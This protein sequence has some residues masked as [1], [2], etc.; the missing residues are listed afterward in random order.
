MQGPSNDR[1]PVLESALG[2]LRGRVGRAA[3]VAAANAL[4][5]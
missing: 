3:E 5:R 4:N 2:W 1:D